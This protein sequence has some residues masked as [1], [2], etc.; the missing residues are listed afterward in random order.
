MMEISGN[1][2]VKA[3]RGQRGESSASPQPGGD[4]HPSAAKPFQ[5]DSDVIC[6]PTSETATC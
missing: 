5:L 2:K 3:Q 6:L 1:K 4:A